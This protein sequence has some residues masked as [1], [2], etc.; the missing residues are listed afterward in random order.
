MSTMPALSAYLA[1]DDVLDGDHP[2]VA[3]LAR[4]LG[5]GSADPEDYA[6]TVYLHVRD[7]IRHSWDA[8]D[9]TVSVSAS[10]T[11]GNGT[12]LC[13]AKAHLA[14]ALTRAG[15]IPSGLSYQS[16]LDDTMGLVLHGLY[17]VH[18]D[19]AWH[20]LDPRGNRPGIDAQFD[21]VTE[22]LAFVP[23]ADLGEADF[24]AIRPTA[25]AGVVAT[26][27]ALPELPPPRRGVLPA[28]PLG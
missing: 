23:D 18:L 19:G 21:L 12:G 28:L 4:S 1:V 9:T 8:G 2:A 14:V 22:R 3:A 15:R 13:F 25:D 10:E 16:L 7:R 27:R 11:L 24:P 17:A 6:R 20:R 26:L 5:A